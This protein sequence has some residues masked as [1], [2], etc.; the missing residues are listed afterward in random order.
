MPRDLWRPPG[1]CRPRQVAPLLTTMQCNRGLPLSRRRGCRTVGG[2]ARLILFS[3]LPLAGGHSVVCVPSAEGEGPPPRPGAGIVAAA[4]VAGSHPLSVCPRA[5]RPDRHLHRRLH[6]Y[7][8]VRERGWVCLVDEGAASSHLPSPRCTCVP[9]PP[10]TCDSG[11]FLVLAL[12][13]PW[14]RGPAAATA[15][16]GFPGALPAALSTFFTHRWRTLVP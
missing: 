15:S 9:G 11:C 2:G 13:I 10:A 6:L 3:R 4:V 7:L 5:C 16:A 1:S 14:A 12:A 8:F